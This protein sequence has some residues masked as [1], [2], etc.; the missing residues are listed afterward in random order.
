MNYMAVSQFLVRRAQWL[1]SVLDWGLKGCLF[2]THRRQSHCIVSLSKILYPL[3]STG[4]TQEDRNC[5]NMTEKLLT[6][7]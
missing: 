1:G 4:S 3:F 2:E 7:M 5:L 6:G